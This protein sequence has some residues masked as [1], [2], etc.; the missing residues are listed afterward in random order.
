[1]NIRTA[2]QKCGMPVKTIRHFELMGFISPIQIKDGDQFYSEQDTEKLKFLN[3]AHSVGFSID[4]C[5]NLLRLYF[6]QRRRPNETNISV[7]AT[8]TITVD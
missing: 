7:P 2:S 4:E 5:R 1:M 8:A 6:K 3:M